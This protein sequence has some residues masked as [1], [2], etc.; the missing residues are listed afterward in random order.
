[1]GG[2]IINGG[3]ETSGAY[4]SSGL[5]GVSAGAVVLAKKGIL[6]GVLVMTNGTNDATLEVYDNAVSVAGTRLIPTMVVPGANRIGG[7][8]IPV[9]ADNGIT[10]SLTGTGA[11]V[12]LYYRET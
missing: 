8:I 3:L 7:V 11:G 12:V 9:E 10:Y 4:R 1:M 6:A 2:T 5:L